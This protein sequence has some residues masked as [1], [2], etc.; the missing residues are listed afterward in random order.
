MS[1]FC[2]QCDDGTK[3]K[4]QTKDVTVEARGESCVVPKVTGWHCPVRGDI[5]FTDSDSSDRVWKGIEAMGEKVKAREAALLAHVRKRLKL[6]QKQAAELTGGG[7]N[8]FS[9]Y[10]RGEAMPMRAVVN[11][12]R[13][14][15]STR[16]W[17]RSW[18]ESSA[19]GYPL[20][21]FENAM[22]IDNILA[23]LISREEL[24]H[25]TH[26]H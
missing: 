3:L 7:H 11:F 4:L 16:S 10:E 2:L 20:R 6:T 26:N 25:A 15:T 18:L 9:R 19:H 1:K 17:L 23:A 13:Y 22:W 14:W 5:E 12:S 21:K 24:S 8:A